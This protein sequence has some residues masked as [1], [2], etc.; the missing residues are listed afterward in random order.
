MSDGEAL[1]AGRRALITGAAGEIG[2]AIAGACLRHGAA[3]VAWDADAAALEALGGVLERRV[4]DVTDARAVDAAAADAEVDVLV[5]AAGVLGAPGP[6]TEM[7]PQA[8]QRVLDVN[9][10]GVFNCCRALLPRMAER[11]A[12]SVVNVASISG[13]SGEPEFAHY[14]ASK[15]GVIGLTESLA[16]E[17][18]AAG[19]RVN[20]V[21]PGAVASRMHD[22]V[23]A[24][25]ADRA[26]TTADQLD[27][28]TIGAAGLRR[29]VTPEDVAKVVV[30]L[31]SDLASGVSRQAIPVTCGIPF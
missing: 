1:L 9:L 13:L 12:G 28:R 29:F 30:F 2:S 5:N 18:G 17:L 31:A 6:V 8:W 27:A 25:F 21:C 14:A 22:A 4:V 3:V 15:F 19:V 20:A 26:G 23:I 16:D 7:P 10:N 11:R 24:V